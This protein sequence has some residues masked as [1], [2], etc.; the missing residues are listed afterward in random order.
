[1]AERVVHR[2]RYRHTGLVAGRDPAA[3]DADSD[4]AHVELLDR[5]AYSDRDAGCD[6]HA[7][8]DIHPD[9]HCNS[10]RN[11]HSDAATVTHAITDAGRQPVARAS[12]RR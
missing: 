9:R 2:R 4:R 5:D 10:D 11:A 1:V 7:A 8:S 12:D 3:I 6:Q